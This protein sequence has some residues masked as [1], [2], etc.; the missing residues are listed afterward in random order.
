MFSGARSLPLHGNSV[1]S[2]LGDRNGHCWGFVYATFCRIKDKGVASLYKELDSS[3]DI[4]SQRVFWAN[5]RFWQDE[6]NHSA[7]FSAVANRFYEQGV[8]AMEGT[9]IPYND[10]REI[11][12]RCLSICKIGNNVFFEIELSSCSKRVAHSLGFYST[13]K[14]VFIMDIN[15]GVTSLSCNSFS[16]RFDALVRG[17]LSYLADPCFDFSHYNIVG[18]LKRG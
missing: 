13:G 9:S 11:G 12:S 6:L 2:Y 10:L 15:R 8:D 14:E 18:Y 17:P 16:D 5:V 1:L 3:V 4:A 7:T